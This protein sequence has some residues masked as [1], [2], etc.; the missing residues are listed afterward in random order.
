MAALAG[1]DDEAA[2]VEAAARLSTLPLQTF[3]I[4][5]GGRQWS[6]MAV[7][8]QDALLQSA[9]QFGVFPY[10]LLLW[11]S[12]VALAD[13][14][15]G[16]DS[17]AARRVLELGAGV[18]L[19]GLAARARGAEV[20]QTDHGREALELCRRNAILNHL[21]GIATRTGDWDRWDDTSRYD[22]IVGSDILYDVEAHAPVLAILQRNLQVGGKVILSDPGR[23]LTPGFVALLE[24]SNFDILQ[25]TRRVPAV[26]PLFPGHAVDVAVIMA[27]RR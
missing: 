26:H 23:P 17:L 22:L 19:A 3:Q 20:V 18:G 5:A 10:G 15:A 7:R 27:R 16:M 21:D 2:A 1:D 25:H 8:D 11:D 9:D 24:A 12:A 13:T 14:L 4:A 6:I